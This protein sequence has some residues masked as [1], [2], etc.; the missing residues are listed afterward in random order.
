MAQY[1]FA[2]WD[3]CLQFIKYLRWKLQI[4]SNA[5]L[6]ASCTHTLTFVNVETNNIGQMF[7]KYLSASLAD[8]A[9]NCQREFQ[10]FTLHL[11]WQ[12]ATVDGCQFLAK[13]RNRTNDPPIANS[14]V[15]A[16]EQQ[17]VYV[18]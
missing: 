1:Y 18:I 16:G 6:L 9:C 14:G 17:S 15:S 4:F 13:C 12:Q 2:L 3:I 10:V 7:E 11:H 8:T 5:P